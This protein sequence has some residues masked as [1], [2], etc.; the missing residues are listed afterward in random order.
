M[1]LCS[2][3]DCGAPARTSGLCQKHYMH[4]YRYADPSIKNRTGPRRDP[5]TTIL[6]EQFP[7]QSRRTRARLAR[8]I[9]LAALGAIDI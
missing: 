7:N 4:N 2:V 6:L 9:R 8:A 1:N 5:A 3:S